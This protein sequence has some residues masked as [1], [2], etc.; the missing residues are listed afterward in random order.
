MYGVQG[1]PDTFTRD[2]R[3]FDGGTLRFVIKSEVDDLVVSTRSGDVEAGTEHSIR[4]S[5]V[6]GFEVGSWVELSIPLVQFTD[7]PPGKPKADL[8]QIKIFFNIA[9]SQESGGTDGEQSFWVDNVR[10]VRSGY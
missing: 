8:S 2:M 1:T 9:S 7:P 4:L 5:S 3:F 6:S 10:W